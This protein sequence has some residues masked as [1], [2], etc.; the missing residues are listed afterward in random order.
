M[1]KLP[2]LKHRIAVIAHRGGKA[3]A[4]ENTLAAFRNAVRL[5]VDYVEVDV[6]A[7]RDGRLVLMHDGTVD[8][9]TNGRGAVKELDW[10]T[11]SALDAGSSV[12]AQFAGE[13]VATF[14]G[15]LNLC[16]GN[17]HVYVDHKDAPTEL[18]LEAIRRHGMEGQVVIYGGVERLKEW[19]RLAPGIPVMPSLPAA[20]ARPG[21]LEEFQRLLPAEVL[22]GNLVDWTAELILQ[23]HACGIQVYVDALG[24]NDNADGFRRA[25]D[26]GVDGIQTDYPD[27]LIQVLGE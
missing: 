2:I 4:P 11:I 20:Y 15:V 1:A 12:S 9:T 14:E 5:G 18:V 21:G 17:T 8:R 24:P 19:K 10:A 13:R 22:D 7:T 16:R 3:L 27:L 25:L 6:R 26:L 23:A